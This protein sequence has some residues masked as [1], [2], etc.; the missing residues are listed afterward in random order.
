MSNKNE[1]DALVASR[2][3]APV[4]SF[5]QPV[6][7][8]LEI[9]LVGELSVVRPDGRT[10]TYPLIPLFDGDALYLT[11]SVLFS[12]KLEH[13]KQNDRVAF[14]LTDPVAMGGR[15]DRATIIGDARIIAEDPHTDWS[16]LLPVWEAKE[17]GIVS[18]LKNR[19]AFPLFFERSLI[20]ITPRR[21]LLWPDGDVGV[22]PQ[23]FAAQE[24]A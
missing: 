9:A 18:F 17:P 1:R 2:L 3:E 22:A 5:P 24:A 16:R 6:R 4:P 23:V 20:E 11:S 12:R 15:R 19:V 13:L 10:V 7:E 14:S 21:V 8:L